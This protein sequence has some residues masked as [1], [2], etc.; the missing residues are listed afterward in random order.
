MPEEQIEDEKLMNATYLNPMSTYGGSIITLTNPDNELYKM[1]LT[2]RSMSMD[3]EGNI[4]KVG[5]P[6]MN[7]LGINSVI[8]MAQTI[9]SR[10]TIMSDLNK[11][12]ITTLIDFLGDTLAKDLMMNRINY[13]IRTVSA[14]C[15]IYFT[16]LAS[17]F[18]CMKRA[19]ESG[20]RRFWKGSQQDVTHRFE[21]G[22]QRQGM[23]G[24]LFGW[25]GQ[26]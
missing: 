11:T 14:R 5:D 1:E 8:G 3:S 15:K 24:K 17:T 18:I 7:D 13:K 10:V 19:F 12:E 4:K 25:G 6:L 22:Q 16:V 20:D 9:L 21:G 23:M 26:K 2:L